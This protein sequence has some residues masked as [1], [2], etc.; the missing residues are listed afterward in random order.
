MRYGLAII[1]SMLL[2]ALIL[3]VAQAFSAPRLPS[4]PLYVVSVDNA[5]ARPIVR[6]RAVR[7]AIE[8]YKGYGVR[9]SRRQGE[10]RPDPFYDLRERGATFFSFNEEFYSWYK[11]LWGE[12]KLTS[13]LAI[14]VLAPPFAIDG[15]RYMAGFAFLGQFFS[16]STAQ[17]YN[18]AGDYRFRHTVVGIAHELGHSIFGCDH[19]AGSNLMNAN[20]YVEQSLI[21]GTGNLLPLGPICAS[22]IKKFSL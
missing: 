13:G 16:Y 19:E 10:R 2:W 1:I 11:T 8:Y 17:E 3:G 7:R 4:V 20:A 22:K 6:D 9:I 15:I 5:Y 21:E 18:T 14:H 12:G